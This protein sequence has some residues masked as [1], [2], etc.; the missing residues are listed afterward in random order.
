MDLVTKRWWSI[1]W[2]CAIM[3][4]SVC[5]EYACPRGIRSQAWGCVYELVPLS[6][7]S[8]KACTRLGVRTAF[9]EHLPGSGEVSFRGRIHP[10]TPSE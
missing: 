9:F 8:N 10:P 4:M 3:V 6:V 5:G 7:P 1:A 2:A